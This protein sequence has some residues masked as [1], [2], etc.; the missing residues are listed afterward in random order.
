MN[1]KPLYIFIAVCYGL[2]LATAGV[3]H[4]TGGVYASLAGTAFASVYMLLPLL[5]VIITQLLCGEKPLRGC[6]IRWKINRWWFVAWI[7]ML[8]LMAAAVP[9]SGLLPGVECTLGTE[10]M[11]QLTG[12]LAQSGISV[13]P[14]GVIALTLLSGLLAGATV[15]ALFAFGEEIAWRGFLARELAHL[16]F[17]KKS[18]LIGAV[19]GIWH[20]PVI[21]MGHNYPAH[22]VTGVFMMVALCLLLSPVFM[23]LREKSASVI[24]AAVAHG[25]MNALAG[26]SLMLLSGYNDLLCGPCGLAGMA[27]LAVT[28]IFVWYAMKNGKNPLVQTTK[29][30]NEKR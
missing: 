16:G 6:G 9:V 13:G 2:S 26:L 1:R 28:D 22:P 5:S 19:W 25:T 4:F 17:W 7:G 14:W 3:F 15:N 12:Q 23:Y 10:P 11:R 21:L 24:V 18:L 29:T 8:L 27:V 20:A 30:I